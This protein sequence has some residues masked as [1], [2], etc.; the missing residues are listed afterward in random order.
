[1]SRRLPPDFADLFECLN[2]AGADYMLVG[3]YAVNAHGYVRATEDLDVW[4]RPSPEN[5]ARVMAAMKNFG[6]PP[7]LCAEDLAKIEGEP[8]TGFRFGR[9]PLAVDL[10][11]SVRGIDFD[12]ALAGSVVQEFDGLRIRI[13]GL[14]A[15]L[16]NK[17]STKRLK[18]AADVEELE[19]LRAL[20]EMK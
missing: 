11:T 20:G 16:V 13:I 7:G 2:E 17:R 1:M 8:P 10:L 6:M 18:D 5:A 15:L 9:R 4:V 14:E 3:G 19:R 12:E